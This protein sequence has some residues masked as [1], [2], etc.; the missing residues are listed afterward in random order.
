MCTK[1]KSLRCIL[2]WTTPGYEQSGGPLTV[3]T[4]ACTPDLKVV[5]SPDLEADNPLMES[6]MD[7]LSGKGKMLY[8]IL[9]ELPA[10]DEV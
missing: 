2:S 10:P 7:S 3:G 4:L 6:G 1:Y 5:D 8:D 9:G